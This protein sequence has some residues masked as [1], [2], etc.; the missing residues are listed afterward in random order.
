[1]HLCNFEIWIFLWYRQFYVG[2]CDT[3]SLQRDDI[4][5]APRTYNCMYIRVASVRI[6]FFLLSSSNVVA[7]RRKLPTPSSKPLYNGPAWFRGYLR[8]I[9][10]S[11]RSRDSSTSRQPCASDFVRDFH[12]RSGRQREFHEIARKTGLIG[13]RAITA[14][15]AR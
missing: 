13:R 10:D 3:V 9:R 1:M 12:A 2:Y 6:R 8:W 4:A 11:F 15:Q 7:A 5:S 14:V